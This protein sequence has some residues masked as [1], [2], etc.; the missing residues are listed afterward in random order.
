MTPRTSNFG[1]SNND[2]SSFFILSRR[3]SAS[4]STSLIFRRTPRARSLLMSH[5]QNPCS[6]AAA[7]ARAS[8][9]LTRR[10]ASLSPHSSSSCKPQVFLH[11]LLHPMEPLETPLQLHSSFVRSLT[12]SLVPNIPMEKAVYSTNERSTRRSYIGSW[13]TNF[14]R[15]TSRLG[16]CPNGEL[17]YFTVCWS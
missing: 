17:S 12:A 4:D 16:C 14:L 7:R 2:I 6:H 3:T 5:K 13:T 10:R 9:I 11:H 8:G 15:S 1:P